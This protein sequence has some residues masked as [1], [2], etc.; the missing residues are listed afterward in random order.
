MPTLNH[1]YNV[2]IAQLESFA[3]QHQ[4]IKGFS[5]GDLPSFDR[6]KEMQFIAMHVTPRTFQVDK[7]AIT[8]NLDI[9]FYDLPLEKQLSQDYIKEVISDTTQVAVDL[10]STIANDDFFG[11]DVLVGLPVT[12]EPMMSEFPDVLSGVMIGLAITTDLQLDFCLVPLEN[13]TATTINVYS[14]VIDFEDNPKN[15]LIYRCDGEFIHACFGTNQTNMTD[16]VEMLNANPPVQV[17]ACFLE[18]GNY[19]DNGDGRVR[20]EMPIAVAESMC[21]PSFLTL[22]AIYD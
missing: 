22:E 21:A 19:F 4:Q 9:F 14:Q 8:Y 13:Q 20:C 5:H 18:Y 17:N 10:V 6:L 7:G 11:D 15:S 1:T 3:T 12:I 16:F 2:I